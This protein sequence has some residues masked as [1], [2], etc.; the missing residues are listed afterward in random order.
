MP[1]TSDNQHVSV[2][3]AEVERL[4][5]PRR[6]ETFWDCKPAFSAL[7]QTGFVAE[8]FNDELRAQ[9]ADPTHL[10]DCRFN[11]LTLRNGN[12]YSLSVTLLER[13]RRYIHTLPAYAMYAPIGGDELRYEQYRLPANYRNEIFDPSLRIERDGAAT[14]VPGDVLCLRSD[15]YVYDFLI[16]QP[17][18]VVKFTS[19]VL[20]TLE[21]LFN[22][23]SLHAWQ[24]NDS[25]LSATQM[26]VAAYVMGRLAHQYSLEPL[27]M[28]TGHPHHAVRWAAIQNLGRLSRTAAMAK[29]EL[30]KD[31]PHPHVRNAAA[32][33]LQQIRQ[34]SPSSS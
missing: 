25:E 15:R 7:V 19:G 17:L 2:F 28:L 33:T 18:L 1:T 30:A 10:P 21:W 8:L 26:R 6:P 32:R 27:S 11:Q 5:D 13:P 3:A 16:D 34:K 4:F 23:D 22:K 9:I 20:Q 14:V 29:L 24:A 31:D 12:G